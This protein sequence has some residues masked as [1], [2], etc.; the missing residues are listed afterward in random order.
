MGQNTIHQA[1]RDALFGGGG[2]GT[3]PSLCAL[4][5]QKPVLETMRQMT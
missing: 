2:L 4:S 3:H 1:V 5:E